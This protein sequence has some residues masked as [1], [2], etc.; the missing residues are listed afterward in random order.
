LKIKQVFFWED[1]EESLADAINRFIK[2]EKDFSPH[3][4]REQTLKFDSEI[5]KNKFKLI[6]FNKYREYVDAKKKYSK[7]EGQKHD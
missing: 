6:V 1:S 2:I 3:K 4:I 5:F 7:R